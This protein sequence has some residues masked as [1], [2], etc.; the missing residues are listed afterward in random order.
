MLQEIKK[1]IRFHIANSIFGVKLINPSHVSQP[2]KEAIESLEQ[3]VADKPELDPSDISDPIVEAQNATTEAIKA[4]PKVEVPEVDL[5]PLEERLEALKRAVEEKEM[6]VN[7]GKTQVDVDTK[8]VVKA[9]QKL[10]KCME[11]MEQKEVTDYTLMLDEMMKIMERP[12]DDTHEKMMCALME[13]MSK[14]DDLMVIAEWLKVIAEKEAPQLPDFPRDNNGYP[15]FT[16]SKVGGGGG[17]GLTAVENA[18]L[19]SVATEETLQAVAGLNIPK[20][21]YIAG[22]ETDTV[23]E[24]Y[25]F[26]TGGSGGTTVAT[27][28]VVFSDSDKT[29]INSI[30]KS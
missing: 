3:T 16:P 1:T 20:F 11:K 21:D 28:V 2:I 5:K 26:K 24:T 12:K 8:S 22:V 29:F 25:T 4:I 9:I 13:K 23:T 10:E 18:A 6:T 7:V 19:L 14:T 17:G 27:V 15:I 30:T